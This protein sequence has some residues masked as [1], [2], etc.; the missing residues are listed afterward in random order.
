MTDS[1][2]MVPVS[3]TPPEALPWAPS[4]AVFRW[5]VTLFY[6]DGSTGEA[7]ATSREAV[8]MTL[9]PYY[10]YQMD[11]CYGPLPSA[12]R[13]LTAIYPEMVTRKSRRND[14]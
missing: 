11:A 14:R 5:P 2:P 13:Q 3:H 7:W 4:E 8:I 9:D 10:R 1:D 6:P 12:K